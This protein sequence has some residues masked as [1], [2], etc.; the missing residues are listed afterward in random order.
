MF[1][2]DECKVMTMVRTTFE[3]C[4]DIIYNYYLMSIS[5]VLNCH[6]D[7]ST[8]TQVFTLMRQ[9][10]SYFQRCEISLSQPVSE[11]RISRYFSRKNVT[12][13]KIALHHGSVFILIN[14]TTILPHK[15]FFMNLCILF[16]FLPIQRYCTFH[17]V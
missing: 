8:K 9:Y 10:S 11:I 6:E 15:Y 16:C 12:L 14:K 2:D 5:L 4:C 13:R 3:R 1:T 17:C 7:P